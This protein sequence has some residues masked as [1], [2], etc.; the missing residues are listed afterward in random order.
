MPRIAPDDLLKPLSPESPCGVDLKSPSHYQR[1]N[2]VLRLAQPDGQEV[3]TG[4]G[5]QRKIDVVYPDPS[6]REVFDGCVELLASGR[7]LEVAVLLTVASTRIDGY[8]GFDGGMAVLRGYIEQQWEHV[9]PKL[10]PE[11]PDPVERMNLLNNMAAPIGTYGDKLQFL[12]RVREA[13]LVENR[14]LGRFSLK[15]LE[16]AAEAARAPKGGNAP[17]YN[18]PSLEMIEAAFKATEPEQLVE[19]VKI[20]ESSLGHIKG[21]SAAFNARVKPGDA[22]NLAALEKM[23]GDALRQVKRF[24]GGEAAADAI[25]G[26]PAVGDAGSRGPGRSASR[27]IPGEVAGLADAKIA[28]EAV[29]KYYAQAE[30]SSPVALAVQCALNLMGKDFLAISEILPPDAVAVFKR[31]RDWSPPA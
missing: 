20:L 6:W 26:G 3:V 25:E 17:A 21:L 27:F 16:L 22:V 30:P 24:V 9:Y 7:N 13:A 4:E 12:A 8:P 11:D 2:E 15:D 19:T 14:Q 28:L 29:T 10:D 5:E 23:L 18:G 31:V 1:F